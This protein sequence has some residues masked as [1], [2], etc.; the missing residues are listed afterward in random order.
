MIN[1]HGQ[2][3]KKRII[4]RFIYIIEKLLTIIGVGGIIG[5]LK[6]WKEIF[7]IVFEFF[8]DFSL[9]Q[10]L[11]DVVRS[12][13]L[14]YEKIINYIFFW[15]PYGIRE[16]IMILI[17]LFLPFLLKYYGLIKNYNKQTFEFRFI[18]IVS[19]LWIAIDINDYFF[20]VTG[21]GKN[22]AW[23]LIWIFVLYYPCLL[24]LNLEKRFKVL[25]FAL[26]WSMLWIVGNSGPSSYVSTNP[27]NKL[28]Y[29]YPA[30][31]LI[32]TFV[33]VKLIARRSV[34]KKEN[35]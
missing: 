4:K 31:L 12:I 21:F 33:I 1:D 19:T 15:A 27:T 6:G 25:V 23:G 2:H 7:K 3:N 5:N 11:L 20:G 10:T 14:I 26:F 29:S 18:L 30:I 16:H 8:K 22:V 13:F 28:F 32:I 24:I 17:F 9:V 35:I 34:S